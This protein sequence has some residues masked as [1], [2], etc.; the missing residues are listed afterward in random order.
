VVIAMSII[1]LMAVTAALFGPALF[2]SACTTQIIPPD[3]RRA[4][5]APYGN[6]DPRDW[7][8]ALAEPDKPNLH[9]VKP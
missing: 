7:T 6:D 5:L 3:P 2:M 9:L 4:K 8:R 1:V